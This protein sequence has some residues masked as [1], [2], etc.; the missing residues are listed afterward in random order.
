MLK[1]AEEKELTR[2]ASIRPL[3]LLAKAIIPL[4]QHLGKPVH[5]VVKAGDLVKTGQLIGSLEDKSIYSPLHS[6]VSGKVIAI[7][8]M[9]QRQWQ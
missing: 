2:G 5:P 8:D 1:L 4:V 7:D 6:P 9:Q 3:K